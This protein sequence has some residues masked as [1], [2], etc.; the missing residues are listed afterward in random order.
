[1][2][3]LHSDLWIADSPLH[4]VGLEVGVRMTAVRLTGPKLLLHSPVAATKELVRKVKEL[5]RVAYLVAPGRLHH[6]FVGDW[7]PPHLSRRRRA[8]KPRGENE[9]SEREG[10]G[11]HGGLPGRGLGRTCHGGELREYH[12]LGSTGLVAARA[13]RSR[14]RLRA[15][16]ER[17]TG[18]HQATHLVAGLT[19][20]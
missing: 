6:L 5:G 8:E 19:G 10:E 13:H 14:K 15:V 16:L 11:P 18:L 17:G 1:V 7:P 12:V 3:Q 9:C 20:S 4:F 2:K